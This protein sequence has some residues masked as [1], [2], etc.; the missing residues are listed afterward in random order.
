MCVS[1]LPPHTLESQNR[2][3]SG[4]IAIR[5]RFKKG[6]FCKNG[7][8]KLRRNLLTSISSGVLSLFFPRNK[9]LC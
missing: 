7:F 1:N 2:D 8:I 5:E 6:D 9:V 3:T 4:F